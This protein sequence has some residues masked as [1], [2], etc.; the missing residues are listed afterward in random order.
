MVPQARAR[1]GVSKEVGT[2]PLLDDSVE[3]HGVGPRT[4]V[5]ESASHIYKSPTI[6]PDG[7]SARLCDA[8]FA[9]ARPRYQLTIPRIV[10]LDDDGDH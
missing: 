3:G 8:E 10:I 9:S 7:P 2:G 5:R 4:A 1:G 6:R